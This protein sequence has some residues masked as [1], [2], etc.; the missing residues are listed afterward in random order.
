M[1]A[2][3]MLSLMTGCTKKAATST[4]RTA[5]QKGAAQTRQR[6]D[7]RTM[8]PHLAAGAGY[9]VPLRHWRGGGA[10]ELVKMMVWRGGGA[11]EPVKK[12]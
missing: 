12:T 10:G 9:L 11:G 6:A 1:F 3:R 7:A 8:A 2:F 5:A 4:E